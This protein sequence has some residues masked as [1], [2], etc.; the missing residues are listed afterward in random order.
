MT[1]PPLCRSRRTLLQRMLATLAPT[2]LGLGGW[3]AASGAGTGDYKALICVSLNGGNDAFNTVLPT[4]DASW[5]AYRQQRAQA[6][7]NSTPIALP[8]PG[9]AA[10]PAADDLRDRWGGVLALSPS[11]QGPNAGWPVA[12]HP[13]LSGLQSLYEA[14]R[15]AVLANVGPLLAPMTRDD[16]ANAR[17]AKPI[18]LF[19]HNDQLANWHTFGPDGT[20]E[21]WG[22][23]LMDLLSAD[24]IQA[25]TDGSD[26]AQM[27]RSFG[28]MAPVFQAPWLNG[29][30]VQPYISGDSGVQGLGDG[31]QVMGSIPLFQAMS[32]LMTLATDERRLVQAY[33]AVT[34]RGLRASALL[35]PRLPAL[36]RTPWS[37]PDA[38]QATTDPLLMYTSPVSGERLSNPLA[39]QLQM[40]LRMIDANLSGGMGLT[41]QC[42]HVS[43]GS[44]D[45]HDKQTQLHAELLAKLDHALL[46]LDT[47]LA[48]MPAGD[49]RNQV[50]AFTVSDF[51]R[52]FTNNGDGTDHG[53]GAHHVIV[54]GAVQGRAVYGRMPVLSA[55][56]ADG[57]YDSIDQIVNGALLPSTSVDQY[58]ATLGRW[59]GLGNSALQGVMPNLARFPS[60]DQDLG[61][62][63]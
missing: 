43:L 24:A 53:W 50:T 32:S 30:V 17:I 44:F 2:A 60:A 31:A 9:V 27:L 29:R 47:A 18:K 37:S 52:S 3:T 10:Q 39:I 51:G 46:Y 54:G 19:S 22:G 58:A 42:F 49:L 62:M 59:M 15:M 4:D 7:A 23:R 8:A 56:Q 21:G 25:A 5:G 48:A 13:C 35:S 28:C 33:Q 63:G 36:G 6:S 14:G 26:R 34:A 61:F 41:R 1:S 57:R 12:L 40:V 16:W 55:R 11:A 45:T 38:L 20:P